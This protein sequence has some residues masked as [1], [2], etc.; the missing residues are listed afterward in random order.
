VELTVS[1]AEDN[2]GLIGTGFI[3]HGLA[4][5]LLTAGH[6]LRVHDVHPERA[7]DLVARG[8]VF[9]A[10]PRAVA[11]ACGV[12]FMALGDDEQVEQVLFGPEGA[13]GDACAGKAFVDTAT[14]PPSR[15]REFAERLGERGA[16][17]LDA[18]LIGGHS[19]GPAE[20]MAVGGPEGAFGRCRPLLETVAKRVVHVGPSGSG[21]VV[22]LMNQ[23]MLCARM[24]STAEAIA[25]A[26]QMGVSLQK[27]DEALGDHGRAVGWLAESATRLCLENDCIVPFEFGTRVGDRSSTL[28]HKGACE[29][30]NLRM[31]KA[32]A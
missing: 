15:S 27:A 22:K 18:P 21:E 23:T 13:A 9:C 19:E 25:Y 30:T 3:G 12:V 26:E 8:A 5:C 20:T 4:D 17:Y 16:D 28:S 6:A 2:V 1:G 14:I 32:D 24:A 10:S 7:D 11:D 31:S 29:G